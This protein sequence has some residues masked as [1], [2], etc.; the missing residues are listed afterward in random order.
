MNTTMANVACVTIC[1]FSP[2]SATISA[3]S[4]RGIMPTPTASTECHPLPAIGRPQPTTLERIASMEITIAVFST[5]PVNSPTL[6]RAPM[7]KKK[8]EGYF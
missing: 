3:T 7:E 1:A 6:S 5:L 4:P 2:A 8:K